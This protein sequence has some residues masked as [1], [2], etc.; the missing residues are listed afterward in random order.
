VCDLETSRIEEAETRKWV[1]K[2]R[3]RRRRR[4]RSV[5][6]NFVNYNGINICFILY[7]RVL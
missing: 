5:N 4:R 2:A 7:P 3:R 1:V 6:G